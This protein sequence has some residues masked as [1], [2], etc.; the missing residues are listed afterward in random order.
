MALDNPAT[1]HDAAKHSRACQWFTLNGAKG[2]SSSANN[3]KVISSTIYWTPL[4]Y[5]LQ[6]PLLSTTRSFLG[7]VL[8]PGVKGQAV[9]DCQTSKLS[10]IESS[11]DGLDA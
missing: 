1:S 4:H 9:L 7:R 3:R 5:N 11:K 6:M 2:T 10:P 8:D